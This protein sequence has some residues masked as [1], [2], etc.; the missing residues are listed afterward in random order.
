MFAKI[1]KL[2]KKEKS[3]VSEQ[4]FPRITVVVGSFEEAV[5][6]TAWF[7]ET[8]GMIDVHFILAGSTES[9]LI[10]QVRNNRDQNV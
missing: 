1:K 3:Y 7:M 8:G 9:I 6:N 4:Y 2:F 5:G 10:L